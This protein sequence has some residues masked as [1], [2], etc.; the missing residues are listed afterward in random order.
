MK[1][2][3]KTAK[4]KVA[5]EGKLYIQVGDLVFVDAFGEHVKSFSLDPALL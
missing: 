5:E 2:S 1:M 3:Q 4:Q